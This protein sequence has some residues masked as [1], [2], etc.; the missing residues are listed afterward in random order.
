[1]AQPVGA[2]VSFERDSA[3]KVTGIMIT[4]PNGNVVKARKILL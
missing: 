1:M 3:G 2:G 4:M